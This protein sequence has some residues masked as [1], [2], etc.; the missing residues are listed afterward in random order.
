[1]ANVG[2][3][4]KSEFVTED[5]LGVGAKCFGVTVLKLVAIEKRSVLYKKQSVERRRP[6]GY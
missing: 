1:M 6:I 3:L 5:S 2:A 4:E